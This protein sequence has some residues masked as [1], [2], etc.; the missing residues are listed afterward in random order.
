MGK[1]VLL[2]VG[3]LYS[4]EQER[5]S[6]QQVRTLPTN[7]HPETAR[8]TQMGTRI[9]NPETR[10]QTRAPAPGNHTPGPRLLAVLRWVPRWFW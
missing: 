10:A 4:R 9:S 7:P 6:R 1:F 2:E 3:W 5:Q 8:G